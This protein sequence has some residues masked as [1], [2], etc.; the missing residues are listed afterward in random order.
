VEHDVKTRTSVTLAR[1]GLGALLVTAACRTTPRGSQTGAADPRAAV[2]R[3][4]G[5]VR[6]QDL[7]GLSA[8]WGTTNGPARDQI[9]R[10]ELERR[11]LLMM[12]YLTHDRY[13]VLGDQQ[14]AGGA[15][16]VRV[17]LTRG[18]LT[19]ATNFT[20]VRGPSDRWY[21]QDVDLTQMQ[22]FCNRRG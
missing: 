19:K 5:A 14:A 3:F 20:V 13:R 21:V 7:Q 6:A 11:E 15:R 9:D 8:V 16:P 22:E 4:M 18:T 10:A 1:L 17:E 12:C 2:E